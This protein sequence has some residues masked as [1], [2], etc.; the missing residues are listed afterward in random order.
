MLTKWF[1]WKFTSLCKILDRAPVAIIIIL[2]LLII[3]RKYE[4]IKIFIITTLS[5]KSWNFEETLLH[6]LNVSSKL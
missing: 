6:D 5:V 1:S 3:Y 4:Y 2:L